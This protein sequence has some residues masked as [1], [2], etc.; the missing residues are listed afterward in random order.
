[1]G[2]VVIHLILK[3]V[4]QLWPGLS[5]QAV[6]YSDHLG[7]LKEVAT[8]LPHKTSARCLHLD[9]MKNK[10]VYCTSMSFV[11]AYSHVKAHQDTNKE[12]R[13]L[14]CPAQLNVYCDSMAKHEI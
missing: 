6:I 3:A 14:H 5:G 2:L 12:F 4:D 7:A 13:N 9:I 11:L 8:L 10:M 1:M